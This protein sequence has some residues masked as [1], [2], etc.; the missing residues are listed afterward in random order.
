MDDRDTVIARLRRGPARV[1]LALTIYGEAANQRNP[2]KLAVGC[3]VV[4][5]ARAWQKSIA[6]VCLTPAQFSCW[7]SNDPNRAKLVEA[8]PLLLDG[9][10]AHG[11]WAECLSAADVALSRL[12]VENGSDPTRGSLYYMTAARY[13]QVLESP[14]TD[15]ANWVL[16]C[17]PVVKIG[18]HVFFAEGV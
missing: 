11:V 17:R 18:A 2:G 13:L 10:A 8:A 9:G 12:S 16:R 15:S 1:V 5:R 7:N 14:L 4:N 6:D 3:V